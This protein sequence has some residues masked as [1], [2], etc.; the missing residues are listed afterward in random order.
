MTGSSFHEPS[1][2]HVS[3]IVNLG[4]EC[5]DEGSEGGQLKL[6]TKSAS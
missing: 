3:A 5:S 6:E 1:A 4:I 2:E